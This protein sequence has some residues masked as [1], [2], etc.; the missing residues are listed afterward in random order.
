M[1]KKSTIEMKQNEDGSVSKKFMIE[2]SI[3][4]EYLNAVPIKNFKASKSNGDFSILTGQNAHYGFKYPM[5]PQP[6]ILQEA[7]IQKQKE[8]MIRA[9]ERRLEEDNHR[10]GS[11]IIHS[12]A[13]QYTNVQQVFYNQLK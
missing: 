4:S 2:T 5:K 9:Y 13:H 11:S 7:I 10:A 6:K 12:L 3:G 8:M 1:V